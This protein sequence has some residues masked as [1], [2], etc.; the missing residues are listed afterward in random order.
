[1]VFGLISIVAGAAGLPISA[2]TVPLGADASALSASSISQS[3]T[4]QGNSQSAGQAE[5]GASPAEDPRLRKCNLIVRAQSTC[6]RSEEI[7]G[8]KV[9]IKDR[10]LYVQGPGLEDCHPFEGFYLE[11]P[12]H[13]TPIRGMVST[14]ARDPPELNWIYADRNDRRLRCGGKTV[15]LPHIAG[16]WD[17][18]EDGK[19]MTLEDWDGFAALEVEPGRWAVCYDTDDDHLAAV[20]TGRQVLECSLE[21]DPCGE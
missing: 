19:Y 12:F 4:S 8:K 20:R 11:Y 17:W 15:S 3:A 21:R 9:V 6:S 5:A 18:E 16:P 2:A 13:G 7:E 1:M 10:A 14:I